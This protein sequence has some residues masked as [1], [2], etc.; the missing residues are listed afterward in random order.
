M[1][2]LSFTLS[3]M[4][5]CWPQ[6][7]QCVLTSRSGSA[8]V[9]SRSPDMTARCGPNRSIVSLLLAGIVANRSSVSN[10]G[11]VVAQ[12]CTRLL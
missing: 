6:K 8:E 3:W 5:H 10:A 7:Q 2:S 9:D 11:G 1:T 4:P 12:R